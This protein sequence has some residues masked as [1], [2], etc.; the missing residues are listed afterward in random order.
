MHEDNAAVVS[1]RFSPNGKHVLAWTLDSCLRLWNYVDGRA[2]K[3]YQGHRNERY[4][5]GG[6]FGIYYPHQHHPHSLP[7]RDNSPDIANE[8]ETVPPAHRFA[9]VAS[10]SEDGEVFL[11]DVGTKDVLQRL[12]GH[13]GVVLGVDAHPSRPWLVTGGLD[14]TVRI[15]RAEPPPLPEE[16]GSLSPQRDEQENRGAEAEELDLV[17]VG[18]PVG[19]EEMEVEE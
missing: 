14:R 16:L 6:C 17:E 9:F 10:G 3:T 11:W 13:R 15:W 4:S 12:L 2:V 8:K 19:G 18:E 7:L 5:L 1:V